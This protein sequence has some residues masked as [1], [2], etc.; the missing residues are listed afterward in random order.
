MPQDIFPLYKRKFIATGN[1]KSPMTRNKFPVIGN[2]FTLTGNEFP[3]TGNTFPVTG[4]ILPVPRIIFSR[5]TRAQHLTLCV[6]C[7]C[8]V[9]CVVV[10]PGWMRCY[11]RSERKDNCTVTISVY[12]TCV[13]TAVGTTK[14]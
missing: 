14:T 5:G 6:W 3:V 8:G 2:K 9:W 7:V 1:N 4:K 11:D 13:H 12:S 10:S